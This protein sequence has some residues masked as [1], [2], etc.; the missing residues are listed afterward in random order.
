MRKN[1]PKN[2]FKI[3]SRNLSKR[4]KIFENVENFKKLKGVGPETLPLLPQAVKWG[5]TILLKIL[6]DP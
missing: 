1:I 3:F 5:T 4:A 2:Y 6:N